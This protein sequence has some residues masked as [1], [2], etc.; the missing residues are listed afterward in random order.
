MVS[1]EKRKN[2]RLVRC[3]CVFGL[4]VS[5]SDIMR[6]PNDETRKEDV[7]EKGNVASVMT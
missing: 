3:E 2:Q 6:D 1:F 4:E 5:Q 7:D